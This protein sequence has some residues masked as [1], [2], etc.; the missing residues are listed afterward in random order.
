[1]REGCDWKITYTTL[2]EAEDGYHR[3]PALEKRRG[4][5]LPY[6]CD[7]HDGYHLGHFNSLGKRALKGWGAFIYNSVNAYARAR[8]KKEAQRDTD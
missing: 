1:M 8:R 6:W 7:K 4:F 2:A 3:T 5:L